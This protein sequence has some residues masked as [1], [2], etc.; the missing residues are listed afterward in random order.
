VDTNLKAETV[1]RQ[2]RSHDTYENSSDNSGD[3]RAIIRKMALYSTPVIA[4]LLADKARAAS[5]DGPKD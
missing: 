2:E 4:A 5:G 3:R 1:N